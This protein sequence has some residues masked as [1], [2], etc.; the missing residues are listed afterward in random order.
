[1][2]IT[3]H[4][5]KRLRAKLS[6]ASCEAN[7]AKPDSAAILSEDV[8]FAIRPGPCR[9]CT[10]WQ[11]WSSNNTMEVTM[12][13]LES[14]IQ[15]PVCTECGWETGPFARGLCKKCYQRLNRKEKKAKQATSTPAHIV[16]QEAPLRPAPTGTSRRVYLACPYTSAEAAV[17]AQRLASATTAANTL[18]RQ[19]H[20]V[21]S[22][23][24]HGAEVGKDLPPDFAFWGASCLSFVEHWATDIYVLMLPGWEASVGVTA[25]VEAAKTL[26]IP[27]TH[28]LPLA[29]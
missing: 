18:I 20:N 22:P 29:M 27:V 8:S 14:E 23:I 28:I 15:A 12:S 24:S 16:Q 7:R 21:F 5:C 13:N 3:L 19:G 10:D 1:M 25:E 11:A 6:L 2:P 17:M 4:E 9:N 26:N